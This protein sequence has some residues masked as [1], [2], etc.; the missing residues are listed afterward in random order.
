ML[1]ILSLHMMIFGIN[2]ENGPKLG[3]NIGSPIICSLRGA[4]WPLRGRS[5]KL[6]WTWLLENLEDNPTSSKNYFQYILHQTPH[7]GLFFMS[8]RLQ[9]F[10]N[11]SLR[12]ITKVLNHT[13]ICF[14]L[15]DV[16]VNNFLQMRVQE[17]QQHPHLGQSNPI[18]FKQTTINRMFCKF[19]KAQRLGGLALR[20]SS[21]EL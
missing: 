12:K 11:P 21:A 3:L 1:T 8:Y 17:N 14:P 16:I 7:I 18:L 6:Y 20:N 5:P 13:F 4:P 15:D 10:F 2:W 19:T 9:H